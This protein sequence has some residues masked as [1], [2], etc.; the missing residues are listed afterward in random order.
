[1]ASLREMGLVAQLAIALVVGAL[2]F[3][4]LD[5]LMVK[6]QQDQNTQNQQLLDQKLA[7]NRTLEQYEKNLPGLER[8]IA[9]LQQQLD[10][11]KTIVPD[12]KEAP[13]FIHLMQ[14]TAASAG[15]EIRRYTSRPVQ[16]REFYSE[17]PFEID[18]DGPYYS[19]V[20]FFERV[21]KLQRIVNINGLQMATP[22]RTGDAKVK[23]SY[24]YAPTETVVASCTATTFFSHDSSMTAPAAMAKAAGR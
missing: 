17:V 3:G 8:Q 15:I 12:E 24:N 6:P 2:V 18:I 19:V 23:A 20:N 9:S 11:Q 1:M 22:K 16:S 4:G 21:A 5:Y 7:A 10:I 13:G 14:D